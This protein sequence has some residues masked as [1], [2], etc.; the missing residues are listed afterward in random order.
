MVVP[1]LLTMAAASSS[2]TFQLLP[3]TIKLDRD[4]YSIWRSTVLSALE[5][6]ELDSFVLA[7]T[8]PLETRIVVVADGADATTEPN[9]A[10]ITWK[11]RDRLGLLWLRSTL[12]DRTLSLVVRAS[13]SRPAW[14]TIEKS[15]QSHTRVRRMQLKIQLQTL[16]K[17]ALSMLEYIEKKRGIADSLAEDLQPI[18]YFNWE[19]AR[20]EQDH[21]LHSSIL[22]TPPVQ[23]SHVAAFTTDRT[24]PRLPNTRSKSRFPVGANNHRSSSPRSRPTC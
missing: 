7:P 20:Q 13:S 22:P 18:S 24:S 19:E 8:P 16:P 10:Y 21:V 4:N 2:L 6:F 11:R 3:I 1:N 15:F 23:P 5:M 17:G 14:V 12:S 9:P